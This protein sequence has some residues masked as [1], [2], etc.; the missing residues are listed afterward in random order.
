MVYRRKTTA[1]L[2]GWYEVDIVGDKCVR[3]RI[4]EDAF[5][6]DTTGPQKD[7]N[8]WGNGWRD[9]YVPVVSEIVKNFYK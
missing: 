3:M 8:N 6:A 9:V 2:A 7:P 4:R 5:W 1:A